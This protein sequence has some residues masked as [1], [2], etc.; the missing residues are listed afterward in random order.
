MPE[1][2]EKVKLLDGKEKLFSERRLSI[3]LHNDFYLGRD[4][5]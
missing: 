4:N 3:T 5:D 2:T 1:K